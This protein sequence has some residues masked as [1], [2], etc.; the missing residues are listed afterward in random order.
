MTQIAMTHLDVLQHFDEL[1][2][3]TRE[4]FLRILA[5][6]GPIFS[7]EQLRDYVMSK[8]DYKDL[9]IET[10]KMPIEMYGYAVA[11]K[12]CDLICTNPRLN[13]QHK[14]GVQ[15][16]EMC[17]FIRKD[18]SKYSRGLSTTPYAKFIKKRDRL[19]LVDI[20]YRGVDMYKDPI[21]VE[22]ETLARLCLRCVDA[23]EQQ[24][25]QIMKDLFH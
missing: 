17:H 14:I 2:P 12:D 21:E 5:A 9:R 11:L 3:K 13:E 23:Y 7:L 10:D 8:R 25:H 16:H 19:S 24:T 4:H 18:V 1:E 15:I 6:L 22:T 20:Y